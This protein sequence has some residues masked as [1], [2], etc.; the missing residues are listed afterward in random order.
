MEQLI[1]MMMVLTF[2]DVVFAGGGGNITFDQSTD[3]L[4][5]DDGAKAIFGS[6]SDGVEIYHAS[7]NSH[8]ADT[9]TGQLTIRNLLEIKNAALDVTDF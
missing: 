8:I 3:D 2:A 4:I 1:L 7:N 9:G 6:S 5:F